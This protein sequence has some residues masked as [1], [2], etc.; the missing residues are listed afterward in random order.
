MTSEQIDLITKSWSRV[1]QDPNLIQSF[2]D[3][4]FEI[5]PSTKHYFPADLT[6]QSE[7][8]AYTLGFVVGNLDRLENIQDAI[9]KLGSTH[10]KLKVKEE[11]YGFMK[12]AL[13]I[14]IDNAL[15]GDNTPT[16]QAWDEVLTYLA[17]SMVNAENHSKNKKKSFLNKIFGN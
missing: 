7:K 5:A 16:I 15:S 6:M 17:E 2:Y 8:L 10:K 14:T 3:K 12:E 9:Q 11:E 1:S 13:L 4:L